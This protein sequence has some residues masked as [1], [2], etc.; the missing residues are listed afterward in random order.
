MTELPFEVFGGCLDGCIIGDNDCQRFNS[1]FDV[2]ESLRRLDGFAE[3]FGNMAAKEKMIV[4]RG[5][6]EIFGSVESDTLVSTCKVSAT[7]LWKDVA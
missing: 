2:R 3:I 6:D 5:E 4:I 7:E 1:T